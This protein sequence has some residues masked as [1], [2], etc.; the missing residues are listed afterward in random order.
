MQLISELLKRVECAK[1]I[2]TLDLTEGYW[3]VPVRKED[4]AKTAFHTP[5]GLY[6]FKWMHFSL[7]RATTTFQCLI[8]WVLASQQWYAALT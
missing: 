6:K 3:Q 7:H 4:Q 2:S 1:F 5:W 8:D